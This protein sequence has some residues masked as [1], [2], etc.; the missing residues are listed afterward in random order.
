[1]Y[2]C[3]VLVNVT[4]C[5]K[6]IWLMK[7]LIKIVLQA[8]QPINILSINMSVPAIVS[9]DIVILLLNLKTVI[10]AFL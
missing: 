2:L 7:Y 5:K 9:S 1:M 6:K 10:A 8:L 4:I 3:V